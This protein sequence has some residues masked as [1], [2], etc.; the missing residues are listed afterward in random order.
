MKKIAIIFLLLLF[1][2]GCSAPAVISGGPLGMEDFNFY[3][4]D[5]IS[6]NVN[7]D[8]TLG[9]IKM[10]ED[11]NTARGF[12]L[13]DDISKFID[14]YKDIEC[15]II[16]KDS[17][18]PNAEIEL[19]KKTTTDILKNRNNLQSKHIQILFKYNYNSLTYINDPKYKV[20][21]SAGSIYRKRQQILFDCKS[22]Y[23][24]YN[25]SLI[26]A[27]EIISWVKFLDKDQEDFVKDIIAKYQNEEELLTIDILEQIDDFTILDSITKF[28][29]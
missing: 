14:L 9:D 10:A 4:G 26:E 20:V 28:L 16:I 6:R 12:K 21:E 15:D 11:E 17:E 24:Y 27:K 5:V 1:A 25:S 13:S 23:D 8:P 29:K 19:F 2:F 7:T 18:D 22:I 3:K